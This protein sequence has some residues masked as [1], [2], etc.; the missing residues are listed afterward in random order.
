MRTDT[1][2]SASHS[3]SVSAVMAKSHGHAA[4]PASVADAKLIAA[5]E[6]LDGDLPAALT[7]KGRALLQTLAD[8]GHYQPEDGMPHESA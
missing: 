3:R 1:R 4:F 2:P 8:G 6:V 5:A 7:G